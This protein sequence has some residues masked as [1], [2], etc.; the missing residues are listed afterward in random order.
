[1]KRLQDKRA[2]V[3]GGASGIGA[4]IGRGFAAEGAHVILADVNE[5]AGAAVARSLIDAGQSAE[6]AALDVASEASWEALRPRLVGPPGLDILVNAAGVFAQHLRHPLDVITLDE[7]RRIMSVNL[8]GTFLGVRIGLT[9]MKE[10]RRGSIIN[11]GSIAGVGGSRGGAAYGTSK[12]A[13]HALTKHA[14][15]SAAR[16][17]YGVRVN[18]IRPGYVW[19]PGTEAKAVAEFGGVQQAREG[20]ATRHPLKVEIHGV[21]IAAAAIYLA[22]DESR[23]V[24]GSDL[25]VDAGVLAALWGVT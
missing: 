7:W 21:D 11:I 3:T 13:V 4:A 15:F 1:M 6:F 8:D 14:A 22:S 20:L 12:G 9:V 19:S 16:A 24:T 2:L 17:G 5:E 10:Y 18:C 23:A 25:D